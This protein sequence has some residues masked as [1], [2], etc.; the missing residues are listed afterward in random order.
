MA[1]FNVQYQPSICCI[2]YQFVSSAINMLYQLSICFISYQYVV[3]GI[4]MLY[5]LS[6]SIFIFSRLHSAAQEQHQTWSVMQISSPVMMGNAFP[7][8]GFVTEKLTVMT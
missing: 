6:I 2:S 8:H 1:Q 5:Q 3:S 4:N 7:C